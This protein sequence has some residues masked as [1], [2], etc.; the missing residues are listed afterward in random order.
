MYK[1]ALISAVEMDCSAHYDLGLLA[2][3]RYYE[4]LEPLRS[5]DILAV[6]TYPSPNLTL[7]LIDVLVDFLATRYATVD[8]LLTGSRWILDHFLE[9]S[10]E[11]GICVRSDK[12]LDE[13]DANSTAELVVV[14]LGNYEAISF[15]MDNPES[16]NDEGQKKVWIVLPLDNS[17]VD[18]M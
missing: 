6:N 17:F 8:L 1:Q 12:E 9:A 14:A 11:A 7:P 2:P 13:P 10:K 18:G 3:E 4:V 5:L 16:Y 15:W